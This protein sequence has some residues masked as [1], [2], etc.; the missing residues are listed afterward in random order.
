MEILII[1]VF[2][3]PQIILIGYLIIALLRSIETAKTKPTEINKWLA[4]EV[5]VLIVCP[6]FGIGINGF[7]TPSGDLNPGSD[8]EF[9]PPILLFA[10]L[11]VFVPSALSYLISKIVLIKYNSILAGQIVFVS[12][13]SLLLIS[14][15][16]FLFI[17]LSGFILVSLFPIIGILVIAPLFTVLLAIYSINSIALLHAQHFQLKDQLVLGFAGILPTVIAFFWFFISS[18]DFGHALTNIL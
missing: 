13:I 18:P 9:Y 2:A 12:A 3:I 17:V 10:I 14:A 11:C 4:L 8:M 5:I 16:P 6:I 15:L 1:G 7:S